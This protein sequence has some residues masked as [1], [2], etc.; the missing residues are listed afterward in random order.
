[1]SPS[2]NPT[3]TIQ[4]TRLNHEDEDRGNMAVFVLWAQDLAYFFPITPNKPN[5]TSSSLHTGRRS[6][7]SNIPIT[8][9]N[10]ADRGKVG[11]QCQSHE[12]RHPRRYHQAVF[13]PQSLRTSE[14]GARANKDD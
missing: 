11:D 1:M 5:G 9:S 7:H 12:Y 6:A 10:R 3:D 14:H 4:E 8:V 13:E 2:T